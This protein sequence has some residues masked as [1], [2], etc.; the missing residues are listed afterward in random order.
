[1]KNTKIIII[2][3]LLLLNSINVYANTSTKQ[4]IDALTNINSSLERI[5]TA[6]TSLT[7]QSE[8]NAYNQKQTKAETITIFKDIKLQINEIK[9]EQLNIAN[10]L[11][12]QKIEIENLKNTISMLKEKYSKIA[13]KDPETLLSKENSLLLIPST[14]KPDKSEDN[15]EL[16]PEIKEEI[17]YENET[18]RFE[19][20]MEN[21]N[22]KDFTEAAI[23]FAANIKDFPEGANFHNNLLYLGL[24]MK[25]LDNKNNACT[26]FAKIINSK[27]EIQEQ[28]KQTA[29]SNF[30][31][32]KC[33]PDTQKTEEINTNVKNEQ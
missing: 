17:S 4:N 19:K 9:E 28:I 22:K 12:V 5:E 31:E 13:T 14:T 23:N 18:T 8:E 30:D 6:I 3:I 10:E 20:A 15:N 11:Q 25:E 27:E 24:S 26:A 32:L 2:S 1:M 16:I 21:F 29:K 7:S 33:N